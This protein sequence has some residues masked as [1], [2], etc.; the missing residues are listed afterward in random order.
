[1]VAFVD[2]LRDPEAP[3]LTIEKLVGVYRVLL[4]RKIAAYTFHMNATSRITDAPTIRSLRFILQDEME[5]WRE[6]EM[7]LQSLIQTPEAVERATRR[8]QALEDL[9]R[10]AGGI[11]GPGTLGTAVGQAEEAA[12]GVNVG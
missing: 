6:G 3:E 1:M 8:Q 12:E 9:I 11:T 7:L 4:P 10:S 5:D 2:A